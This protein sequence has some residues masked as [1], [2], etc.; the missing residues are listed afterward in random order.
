MNARKTW[1]NLEV[2]DRTNV[3][4]LA[5]T[6][7]Q[8]QAK[9]DQ[10]YRATNITSSLMIK[11]K[12]LSFPATITVCNPFCGI[13]TVVGV[14]VSDECVTTMQQYFDE[15]FETT[16][17]RMKVFVF[18]AFRN[19]CGLPKNKSKSPVEYVKEWALRFWN[20]L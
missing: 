20:T 9:Y 17:K 18:N 10:G 11:I 1:I 13:P 12:R 15:D 3:E 8:E 5:P 19:T 14:E 2:V 6:N 4:Y 7:Q 16:K